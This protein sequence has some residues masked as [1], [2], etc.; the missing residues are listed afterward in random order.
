MR[1][2]IAACGYYFLSYQIPSFDAR[3]ET[4][5]FRSLSKNY[6]CNGKF[7]VCA[8]EREGAAARLALDRMPRNALLRKACGEQSE[9]FCVATQHKSNGIF[10]DCQKSPQDFFDSLKKRAAVKRP[11]SGFSMD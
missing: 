3:A 11:F 8:G 5:F 1:E 7:S 10:A 6:P 9:D 4:T 2:I